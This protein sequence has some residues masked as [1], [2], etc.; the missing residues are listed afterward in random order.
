M[1]I[2]AAAGTLVPSVCGMNQRHIPAMSTSLDRQPP[3]MWR[4]PSYPAVPGRPYRYAYYMCVCVCVCVCAYT[5]IDINNGV[6]RHRRK[7]DMG[8][9]ERD[10][11]IGKR[12]R[13]FEA[14]KVLILFARSTPEAWQAV[15]APAVSVTGGLTGLV[16]LQKPIA[17]AAAATRWPRRGVSPM[18]GV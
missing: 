9:H 1:G 7:A 18:C 2:A 6:P 12:L 17:I 8:A 13:P 14:L 16:Q 15:V 5:D 4:S 11:R 3:R 10:E